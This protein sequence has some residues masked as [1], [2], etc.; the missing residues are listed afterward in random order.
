MHYTAEWGNRITVTLLLLFPK[1]LSYHFDESLRCI[2]DVSDSD[3]TEMSPPQTL[4]N[5]TLWSGRA[6]NMRR[7]VNVWDKS[8]YLR[9]CETRERVPRGTWVRLRIC[10]QQTFS[11]V[12]VQSASYL[13]C[14]DPALW[15]VVR[16]AAPACDWLLNIPH[17]A[18]CFKCVA[19]MV[20][21][22]LASSVP[23][24]LFIHDFC[25]SISFSIP[26]YGNGI[27]EIH[28]EKKCKKE[29]KFTKVHTISPYEWNH[30]IKDKDCGVLCQFSSKK[31]QG[32]CF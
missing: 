32:P 20:V 14:P 22:W 2:C 23:F 5:F 25:V 30:S 7:T 31:C 8:F 27:I 11:I 29:K 17:Q 26:T 15:L 3:A 1:H 16:K 13:C 18:G 19:A 4:K 24:C 12:S 10:P 21:W 28:S 9:Q 6:N